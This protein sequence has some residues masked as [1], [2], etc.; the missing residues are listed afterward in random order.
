M[1]D[2]SPNDIPEI[3]VVVPV[4]DEEGSAGELA[5]RLVEV[6]ATTGRTF[7]IIFISVLHCFLRWLGGCGE[8]RATVSTIALRLALLETLGGHARRR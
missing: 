3:S 8:C 7:E 6:L 4:L 2:E 1:T 5:R